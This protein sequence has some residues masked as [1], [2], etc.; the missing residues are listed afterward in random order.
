[1]PFGRFKGFLL[2]DIPN[3]YLSWLAG[4]DDLRE[5]L[6]SAVEREFRRRHNEEEPEPAAPAGAACPDPRVADEL[7]TAGFKSL[8]RKYHP[9]MGGSHES[10]LAVNR[11]AEWLRAL[12]RRLA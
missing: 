5:P 4:L 11:V 9:D 12:L 8:A 6:A 10:M 2:S 3:W 1:M 7:V